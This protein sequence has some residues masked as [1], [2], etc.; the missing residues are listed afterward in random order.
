MPG[1]LSTTDAVI[2]EQRVAAM[3]SGVCPDDP[4]TLEQRRADAFGAMGTGALHLA[5]RCG[6]P[7]CPAAIDDG[8]GSS[9]LVHAIADQASLD[10][11]VDPLLHGKGSAPKED[12]APAEQQQ[13]APTPPPRRKAA[14]IPGAKGAIVPAPLLAELIAHGAKVRCVGDPIESEDRYRPSTALQE[15]VRTRDLTCRFP[16]CDR[17][18]EYADID[19]TVAWPAGATHPGNLKCYCRKYHLVKTFWEGWTDRQDPDGTVVI[20]NPSGLSYTTKPFSQL[21]FPQWNTTTPPPPGEQA[22][23]P[24]GPGRHL[25]MPTRRHTRAQSRIA[26]I[27]AERR[28][29]A[30][31]RAL[32]AERSTAAPPRAVD[33]RPSP[34]EFPP[35]GYIPDYGNDPPPF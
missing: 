25:M 27:T 12:P 4:R 21:L 19:H 23:A 33:R 11:P 16:G 14:L 29:N 15:F 1:R 20:T 31:E 5:C 3:A 35:A 32:D 34:Y 26:R 9:F 28:L 24:T 13:P 17:P 2:V 22:A 7:N 10:E 18:A 30:T 8:R 6:D